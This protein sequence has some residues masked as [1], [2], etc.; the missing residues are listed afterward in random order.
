MKQIKKIIAVTI[1]ALS[2]MAM[3]ACGSAEDKLVGRWLDPDSHTT[4]FEF[5]KDGTYTQ[6]GQYGSGTWSI[7][8]DGRLKLVDFYG[9]T[10]TVPYIVD[11]DTLTFPNGSSDPSYER[12]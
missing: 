10:M 5:Y 9:S 4:V 1:S 8:S 6:Q 12:G 11:R 3:V 7:L 2:L